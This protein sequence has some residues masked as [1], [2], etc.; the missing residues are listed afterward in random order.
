MSA[1]SGACL[2]RERSRVKNP[3]ARKR[4]YLKGKIGETIIGYCVLD[5]NMY[6]LFR[7]GIVNYVNKYYTY[8]VLNIIWYP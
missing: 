8:V 2:Q 6:I 3:K 7:Y 1:S 5:Y 4:T